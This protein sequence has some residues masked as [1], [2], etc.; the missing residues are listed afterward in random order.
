[1]EL[2]LELRT[3]VSAGFG[4]GTALLVY[5]FVLARARAI[6]ARRMAAFVVGDVHLEARAPTRTLD[7]KQLARAVTAGIR[8]R[9]GLVRM[10]MIVL[11]LGAIALGFITGSFLWL[12][13]AL[14]CAASIF[15]VSRKSKRER[16]LEEQAPAALEMLAAG[17]RAGYSVPQALSLVARESPIPTSEEFGIVER[18][19]TLGLDL[20]TAMARMAQRTTNEDYEFVS[21]I[22]TVQHDTGGNLA[23][24]LDSVAATLRDRYELRLLVAALTAQQRLSS[25][26]LTLL[27]VAVLTFLTISNRSFVEPL[28]TQDI[29]RMMLGL[30]GIL[31][32]LGWS[33]MRSMGRIEV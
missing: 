3:L 10:L 12:L 1:V 22:I 5:G 19:I 25:I 13:V 28:Y 32:T 30:V 9:A 14:G 29:G 27:P 31:L 8:A 23:Q 15:F 11:A 4:L 2:G 7:L 20:A 18:E 6:T 33:V 21:I 26:V 17:L 24:I 16:L